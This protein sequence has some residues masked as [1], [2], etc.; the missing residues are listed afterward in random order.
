MAGAPLGALAGG[1][2]LESIG[3]PATILVLSGWTLALA[4]VST[5]SRSRR[6]GP[7]ATE[8]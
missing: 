4:V 1:V 8:Q 7:Q 3:G 5:H 2:L 6:E